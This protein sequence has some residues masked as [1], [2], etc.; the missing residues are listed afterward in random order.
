MSFMFWAGM[1]NKCAIE[2]VHGF[3]TLFR[4][5]NNGKLSIVLLLEEH[6]HECL[7]IF[8]SQLSIIRM[9]L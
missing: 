6:F 7:L 9:D 8:F 4:E 5:K 2:I 3:D 1:M